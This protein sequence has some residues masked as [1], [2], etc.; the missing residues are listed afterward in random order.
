M[1]LYKLEDQLRRI[2]PNLVIPY[3]DWTFDASRPGSSVIFQDRWFS[4]ATQGCVTTGNFALANYRVNHPSQRC[5]QR[6]FV[7]DNT[8]V[9]RPEL[10]RLLSISRDF[11]TLYRNINIVPHGVPHVTVGGDMANGYS[12]NDPLFYLHHAFVDKVWFDWQRAGGGNEYPFDRNARMPVFNEPVSNVID[13]AAPNYCIRYQNP[14]SIRGQD[15]PPNREDSDSAANSTQEALPPRFV[16]SPIILPEGPLGQVTDAFLKMHKVSRSEYDRVR[17]IIEK[18]RNEH[19]IEDHGP[20]DDDFTFP[21]DVLL[22]SNNE[23]STEDSFAAAE[24]PEKEDSDSNPVQDAASLLP[25]RFASPP[26]PQ[27]LTDL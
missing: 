22:S 17:E 4:P 2:R 6:G 10:N 24:E 20:L 27:N 15:P 19:D 3:W 13:P 25:S 11:R 14:R 16:W 12:P 18:M 23:T 7:A 26:K 21:N 5:L 8:F 1:L 9:S